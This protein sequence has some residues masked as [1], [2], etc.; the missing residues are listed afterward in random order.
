MNSASLSA[1]RS[2]H[3]AVDLSQHVHHHYNEELTVAQAQEIM[4][5]S[6]SFCPKCKESG[7]EVCER[8]SFGVYAGKM[9]E[10]CAVRGYRDRCG[11]G[12]P[13]G[14]QAEID[15]IIEPSDYY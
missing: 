15:E 11:I 6:E 10:T 8:Y 12:R 3:D 13:Q 4:E 2:C 14:T 1:A 9:C 5:A 7:Q